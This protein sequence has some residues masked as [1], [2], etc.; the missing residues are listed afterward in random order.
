MI[1][2]I[3]NGLE[4]SF[5]A[6]LHTGCTKYYVKDTSIDSVADLKGKKIGVPAM[7][8][9]S[10]VALKRKLYDEGIGVTTDNLEVEWVVYALTDLPLALEN[11]A[12]DV[13][14]LHDPVAYS[15]ETEYGFKKIL[16][17]STDEKFANEYLDYMQAKFYPLLDPD[18][19]P[20]QPKE[21][22]WHINLHRSHT[23]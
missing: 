23:D 12:I 14:A 16:D 15:A 13:A 21:N 5:T 1:P 19:W 17:L 22:D 3:D 20:K 10:V 18:V 4:I 11:G 6:G 7:G 2:Q 9:S 8:D